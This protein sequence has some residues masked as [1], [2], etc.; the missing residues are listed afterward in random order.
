MNFMIAIL[1]AISSIMLMTSV[2]QLLMIVIKFALD[3]IVSYIVSNKAVLV[4]SE[5]RGV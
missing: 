2:T 5:V 1:I 4:L 3:V